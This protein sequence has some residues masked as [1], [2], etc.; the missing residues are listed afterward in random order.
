MKIMVIIC[1]FVLGVAWHK[2]DAQALSSGRSGG[3]GATCSPITIFL[4]SKT[5]LEKG[6]WSLCSGVSLNKNCLPHTSLGGNLL[7]QYHGSIPIYG[8]FNVDGIVA[9]EA[10]AYLGMAANRA[11]PLGEMSL[12]A[13]VD[14]AYDLGFDSGL[15]SGISFKMGTLGSLRMR[16]N[17]GFSRLINLDDRKLKTR[18]LDVGFDFRF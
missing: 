10:G 7:K 18:R 9:L 12:P 3:G 17:Y 6:R 15:V 4:K 14:T 2:C 1:L 13:Y 8:S 5:L 16:Y 11:Q